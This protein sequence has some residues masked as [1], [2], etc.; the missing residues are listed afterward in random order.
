MLLIA[1]SILGLALKMNPVEV[2]GFNKYAT[3]K[4]ANDNS[5]F[6]FNYPSQL[7][8][9]S[10]DSIL[11]DGDNKEVIELVFK[12]NDSEQRLSVRKAILDYPYLV[13]LEGID[14]N[15]SRYFGT[16]D[17]QI[18][19]R[20]VEGTEEDNYFVGV[21]KAKDYQYAVISEFI[22]TESEMLHYIEPIK[23]DIK[24]Q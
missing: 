13:D 12:K 2:S 3:L 16:D 22:L 1:L 19:L 20:G 5:E 15:K 6:Q 14:L 17:I 21:V 24:D 9:F 7:E 11:T 4:E 23:K 10:L 18:E 8:G